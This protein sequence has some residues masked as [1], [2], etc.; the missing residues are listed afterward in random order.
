MLSEANRRGW[1]IAIHASSGTAADATALVLDTLEAADREVPIRGR[2]FSY[3]HGLGLL[4]PRDFLRVRDL[5]MTI[6]A[7]PLLCYFGAARSFNM[8]E[9]MSRVRIAK[10]VYGNPHERAVRDWGMPLKDWL[11][12]GILVTGGTDNPAVVYD[13]DHPLL[14]MYSAISGETLA[15]VLLPGQQVT[16]AQALRMWTLDNARAV[17]QED[18]R[19]SIEVGKLADMVVLSDDILTCDLE[20]IKDVVVVATI[21]GG[22]VVYE[23]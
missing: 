10:Q 23:R 9:I 4:E 20:R 16:R 21:V 7:D 8:H 15:G 1:T 3:E 11:D 18:R 17:F 19:G 6:A 14:G 2:R 13:I 5:G 22:S 12:A